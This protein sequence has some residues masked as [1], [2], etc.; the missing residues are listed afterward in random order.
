MGVYTFQTTPLKAPR[1]WTRANE[2]G[3]AYDE[4]D[5]PGSGDSAAAPTAAITDGAAAHESDQQ[6][7]AEGVAEG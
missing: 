7:V 2:F 1:C 4:D 3:R 5:A 6:G